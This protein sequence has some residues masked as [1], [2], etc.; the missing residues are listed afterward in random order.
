MMLLCAELKKKKKKNEARLKSLC[1]LVGAQV[2]EIPLVQSNYQW[3]TVKPGERCKW[4]PTRVCLG[5]VLLNAFINDL[6]ESN[7]L[8]RE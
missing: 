2:V 5:S 7:D 1:S 6:D 3:F 4:G 8:Y